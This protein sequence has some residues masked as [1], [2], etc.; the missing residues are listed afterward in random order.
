M[1][2][3]IIS[4]RRYIA[5][6]TDGAL[7]AHKTLRI[8]QSS[9][10]VIPARWSAANARLESVALNGADRPVCMYSKN[11]NIEHKLVAAGISFQWLDAAEAQALAS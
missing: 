8:L 1:N 7:V 10:E 2:S 3:S 5:I 6:L 4:G 9:G 11:P